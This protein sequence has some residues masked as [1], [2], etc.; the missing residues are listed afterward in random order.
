M[1]ITNVLNKAQAIT[2]K[3]GTGKTTKLLELVDEHIEQEGL[4]YVILTPNKA[5]AEQ[6]KRRTETDNKLH[7]DKILAINDFNAIPIKSAIR[8]IDIYIDEIN[9]MEIKYL[10][11]F[12]REFSPIS[13]VIAYTYDDP[14]PIVTG[15]YGD[16]K[17]KFLLRVPHVNNL[18]YA[19]DP[20]GKIIVTELNR[21][22]NCLYEFNQSEMEHYELD[23]EYI[24]QIAVIGR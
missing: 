22:K 20:D 24:E 7:G 5:M 23:Q 16:T 4:N 17:T 11:E 3:R 6:L 14:R 8:D 18:Y 1:N 12:V 19:L 10:Y 15:R 2:G 9:L 13:R 21:F